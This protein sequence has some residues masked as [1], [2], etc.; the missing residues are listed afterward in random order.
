[1][2]A[3]TFKLKG[4]SYEV[5]R[6]VLGVYPKDAEGEFAERTVKEISYSINDD[7]NY[8]ENEAYRELKEWFYHLKV[9]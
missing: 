3:I 8:Y 2:Y 5:C 7:T 6:A 9:N 1:M 4:I